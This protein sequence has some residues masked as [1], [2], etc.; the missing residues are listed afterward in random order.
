LAIVQSSADESKVIA[1]QAPDG[2][3]P[4]PAL[5]CAPV[6]PE[7]VSACASV[8]AEVAPV[9]APAGR[10]ADAVR[11]LLV[12]CEA[13]VSDGSCR[14]AVADDARVGEGRQACPCGPQ[15]LR[16]RPVRL[17]GS[18]LARTVLRVAGWR[19]RFDG[20]PAR[21]GVIVVYP[22]TSNWDFV[23][24]MLAKWAIGLPLAFWGKDTLFRIPLFGRWL[25]WVGG[26]PIDRRAAQ[27]VVAQTAERLRA[28]R[29]ADEF[30]WLGLAP[31]G[32]RRRTEGWRSGFY[33]VAVQAQVPVVLAYMDYARREIGLDSAWRVHGDAASDLARFAE[34]LAGR[35][36]RI[37]GNAAPVRLL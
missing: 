35:A 28:A 31:E 36:G 6:G 18:A 25:R 17:A 27:G 1:P 9:A 14:Y 23:L 29:A 20:L 16:E 22:H 11:A 30:M 15:E 34:R 32:T 4:V 37:P 3:T 8:A 5:A 10:D 13:R 19:I 21:Q 2:G 33:H 24:G 7:A 12:A 26:L